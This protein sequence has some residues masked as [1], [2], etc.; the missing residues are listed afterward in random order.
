MIL[1]ESVVAVRPHLPA[2]MG[3]VGGVGE[4]GGILAAVVQQPL[5]LDTI[6][7]LLPDQRQALAIDWRRGQ[8]ELQREYDRLRTLAREARA[9][10]EGIPRVPTFVRW[11]RDFPELVLVGLALFALFLAVSRRVFVR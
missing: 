7:R 3:V 2:L 1:L 9:R 4:P 6:R 5:L 10:A 8:S 11:L